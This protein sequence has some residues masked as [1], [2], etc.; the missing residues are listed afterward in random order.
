MSTTIIT[1]QSTTDVKVVKGDGSETYWSGVKQHQFIDSY[2]DCN[3]QTLVLEH[4]VNLMTVR[5]KAECFTSLA[6]EHVRTLFDVISIIRKADF[7]VGG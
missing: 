5:E 7:L 3:S 4:V 6:A 1:H 2:V